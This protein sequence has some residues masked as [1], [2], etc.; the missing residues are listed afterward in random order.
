MNRLLALDPGTTHTGWVVL[1]HGRVVAC[2]AEED[3]DH[4]LA[5]IEAGEFGGFYVGELCA[6]EMIASYGMPVGAEVF[7]TVWWIGRYCEAWRRHHGRLPARIKRLEVKS[8]LCHSAKA[9][10]G[11]VR[12]ALIDRLGPP[13]TKKAP[14]PTYGVSS[15]AWAAL[16]VGVT[17]LDQLAV[18]EL[19]PATDRAA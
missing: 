13:G 12:Q 18:R 2:A 6:I 4:V 7:E 1:E 15:H 16:A 11:N 14:G 17:Y 8:H 9:K 10:D 3:N 19:H 5:M